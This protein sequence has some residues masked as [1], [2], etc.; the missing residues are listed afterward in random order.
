MKTVGASSRVRAAVRA[1]VLGAGFV[2]FSA[3]PG[4]GRQTFEIY[5]LGLSDPE[6]I[7][8]SVSALLG[9]ADRL[10]RDDRGGRLLVLADAETH[11][12]IAMLMRALAPLS[13]NVRIEVAFQ[14][15][16]E[17]RDSGF[18]LSARGRILLPRDGAPAGEGGLSGRVWNREDRMDRHT[19]QSLL[20]ASGREAVLRV[21]ERVPYVSWF[22]DY[23][24]RY[25]F[26]QARVAW[27]DVG[28]FLVVQ[29]TVI[30]SG[31]EIRIRLVPELSG[32][33]EGS[34]FR[35]RF[36][37]AATE[38]VVRSG[39]T[40]SLGGLA[41]DEAFYSRFL[42]GASRSGRIHSLDIRLTPT[43]LD[44]GPAPVPDPRRGIRQEPE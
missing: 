43:L 26:L 22:C 34:P 12:R 19:V 40:V 38:V 14:E 11:A 36:A 9:P 28:A 10:V 24:R 6:V 42:V 41:R 31:P 8:Q 20:V 2:L 18:D 13:R 4:I 35:V 3:V 1:A 23:G 16:G 27:Q 33:A 5:P 37:T 30:G 32:I 15:R 44:A 17:D 39:Q 29:P 7:E 25:G 21:G